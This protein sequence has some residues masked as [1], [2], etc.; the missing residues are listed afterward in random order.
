MIFVC[1][2]NK[3]NIFFPQDAEQQC[4]VSR[5]ESLPF[6]SMRVVVKEVP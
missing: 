1:Q 5:F 4:R 2:N 3:E 6:Q